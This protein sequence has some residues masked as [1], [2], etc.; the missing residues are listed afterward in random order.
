MKA[1][2]FRIFGI[3]S[4]ADFCLTWL[5]WKYFGK[6]IF[7]CASEMTASAFVLLINHW[8]T[9]CHKYRL[10]LKIYTP[11]STHTHKQY[12]SHKI[13]HIIVIIITRAKWICTCIQ[14][15]LCAWSFASSTSTPLTA[16]KKINAQLCS[17][18]FAGVCEI[19]RE[20]CGWVREWEYWGR[21]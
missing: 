19:E 17:I 14:T 12:Y 3:F 9:G 10:Y 15:N 8:K 4:I 11:T 7:Y 18:G 21:V 16:K 2:S 5:T 1:Q 6:G 13:I 20:R